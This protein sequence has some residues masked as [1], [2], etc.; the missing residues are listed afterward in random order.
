MKC[1]IG[2]SL[3]VSTLFLGCS[4][5]REPI[6]D[7]GTPADAAVIESS[8]SPPD[9]SMD[10]PGPDGYIDLFD[11]FP[12]SDAGCPV[13]IRDRCG[14]QIN[15]CFNNPACTAGLL[16]TVQM[17]A[18]G[19][20]GDSGVSTTSLL[21]VLGCFNGDQA[22]A[23]LAIGSFTCLT[24]TCGPACGLVVD[25]GSDARPPS[26]DVQTPP[27]AGADA[28]PEDASADATTETGPGSDSGENAD[29]DGATP[30]DDAVGDVT[31]ETGGQL[32]TAPPM[33]VT[34]DATPDATPPDEGGAD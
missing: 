26:P 8:V 34:P 20:L 2:A 12:P 31:P 29:G 10:A 27:D 7:A 32:D 13:C 17:C 6:P 4:D 14:A 24:T 21:C 23:F 1:L 28:L 16:C 18:G 5:E 30:G 25:A 9:A 3:V 33:D 19:L 15:A 11:V 22:L